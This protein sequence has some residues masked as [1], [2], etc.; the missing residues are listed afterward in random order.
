MSSPMQLL[1]ELFY[2]SMSCI[3]LRFLS[4]NKVYTHS[5]YANE[6]LAP[7]A[8]AS[9]SPV[10]LGCTRSAAAAPITTAIQ[11]CLIPLRSG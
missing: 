1:N 6:T 10:D 8:E 9:M 2:P 3:L 7:L 11:C 4:L 5:L